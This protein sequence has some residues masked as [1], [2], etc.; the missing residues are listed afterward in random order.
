MGKRR[1][2]GKVALITGA[3]R[4]I[5]LAT[6]ERIVGGG[7]QVCITAR[8]P[9]PLAEAVAALGG[10]SVALAVPGRADDDDHQVEAVSRAIEQF[11]RLDILVNN[12]GTSPATGPLMGADMGAIRKT[13]EVNV[14]AA[15]SFVDVAHRS[16]LREHGGAI[17]NVASVA[18]LRP[19]EF[20]GAY[21][22]SKATLIHLTEQLAFE[23]SPGIR[24]NCVAPAVVKT[25]LATGMF[26]GR[27]AE[28]TAAYP[29]RRLGA[30]VDV[31]DAIAYL[32]SDDASWVTG[33]TL[34]IDGGL[35][36]RGGV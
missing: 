27:E 18:G 23:L 34:V 13:L 11:G 7:G 30:P 4:G 28:V 19:T 5:G 12:T 2:E 26:D 20:I 31:A 9:E 25:R 15:L 10:P 14:L 36:L 6:A 35:L 3:S 1:F 22:M 32:A 24:V 21:G 16:W 29:M 8:K 33:H 17:V